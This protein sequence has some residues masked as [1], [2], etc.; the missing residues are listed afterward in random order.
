[1]AEAYAIQFLT[2]VMQ[3]NNTS[4]RF[5]GISIV[6]SHA[7]KNSKKYLSKY[8]DT[9]YNKNNIFR[10]PMLILSI[11]QFCNRYHQ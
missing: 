1:M 5:N 11:S 9:F 3:E 8:G 10:I 2:T 4:R 6:D 7:G